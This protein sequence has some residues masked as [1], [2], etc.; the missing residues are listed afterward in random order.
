MIRFPVSPWSASATQSVESWNRELRRS[1]GA[2]WSARP[3][4]G[5]DPNVSYRLSSVGALS[6]LGISVSSPITYASVPRR[7]SAESGRVFYIHMGNA[8]NRMNMHGKQILQYP[9]EC[10]LGDSIIHTTSACDTPHATLCAG[11]PCDMLRNY[12]PNPERFVGRHLDRCSTYYRIVPTLL[13]SLYRVSTAGADAAAGT[14]LVN[15][16]LRIFSRWC[17]LSNL[18]DAA[19]SQRTVCYVRIKQI[20]TADIRDPAL[21]VESIAERIGV[22]TRYLQRLFAQQND[23]IS[24]CIRRERLRGCSMDLRDAALADRSITDIAFSWG[25][26]SASHFSQSF[27]TEYGMTA[28][29]YR[30]C[31]SR[32]LP[33]G[34][35]DEVAGLLVLASEQCL[36]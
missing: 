18:G 6:M 1:M 31:D 16:L 34:L 12:L 13:S 24:R 21:S 17:T 4:F 28:R 9:G 14:R 3:P 2:C 35:K 23:C 20:I 8:P 5:H 30:H 33:D 29:E 22:S 10:M 19:G 11:I 27:R 7:S 36:S 15:G 25:F 32:G 26:N